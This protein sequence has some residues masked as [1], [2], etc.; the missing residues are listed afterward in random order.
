MADEYEAVEF[1]A[2][3]NTRL[4]DGGAV[5]AGI[6]LNLNV[7]FKNR[8]TGLRNFVPTAV[9]LLRKA[10]AV[11]ADYHSVLENNAV[12]NAALLSHDCVR[13]GEEVIANFRAVINRYE[14]VQH[15][16]SSNFHLFVDKAVGADVRAFSDTSRVGDNGSRMDSRFV[17]RRVME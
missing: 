13:M 3:A 17:A 4:A 5:D 1:C 12:A 9:W 8:W 2:P 11:G 16:S 10:K 6:G 7:V 15:G 14:A